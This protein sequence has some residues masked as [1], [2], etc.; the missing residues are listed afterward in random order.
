MFRFLICSSILAIICK[1][2]DCWL[3]LFVYFA[4]FAL[5][6]LKLLQLL[7][8][9][10]KDAILLIKEIKNGTYFRRIY[11]VYGI[12]G[13]YGQGKTVEMAREYLHFQHKTVFHNPDDYIFVSNF[14]LADTQH[15]EN[16]SDVMK[17]YALALNTGKGLVVF[18]DEIQNEYPE[19]DR[20]FPQAFRAL[21]TQNRKG[22][23]VRLIWS[24]QDYTRVNKNIR[25][26]TTQVNQMRCFFGRYMIRSIYNRATY[27]DYYACT[28][29]MQKVKRKPLRTHIYIQTDEIR[30][31]FD[32][33]K[34]LNVAKKHLQLD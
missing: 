31:V 10:L 23:G 22:K 21:L 12:V 7:I 6:E 18:W 4:Y 28:D 5:F 25:L 27:E 8:V 14:D 9:K 3:F 11:G 29:V 15:F 2:V 30:S 1:C 24:T 17:Y 32:S 34:M 13:E 26:M 20:A 19:N 16:L 33:F